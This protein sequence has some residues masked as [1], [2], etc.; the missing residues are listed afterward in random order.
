[1]T[2]DGKIRKGASGTQPYPDG[3]QMVPAERELLRIARNSWRFDNLLALETYARVQHFDGPTR[4]IDV[5]K[6]PC[7]GA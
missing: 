4:S 3:D 7:T 2:L 1:M 5:T 6:N